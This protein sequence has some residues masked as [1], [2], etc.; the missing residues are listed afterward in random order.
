VTTGTWHIADRL[1]HRYTCGIPR[2]LR[3]QLFGF[4]TEN[5]VN[6][7]NKSTSFLLIGQEFTGIT[8]GLAAFLLEDKI[9]AALETL[10]D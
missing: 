7:K 5:R 4:S 2:W 8:H 6:L 3:L 9:P 1:W 10:L